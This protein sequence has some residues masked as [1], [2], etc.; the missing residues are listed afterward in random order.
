MSENGKTKYLWQLLPVVSCL[1]VAL[2][3]LT[4]PLQ[5]YDTFWH[6]A[7]GRAMV[8]TGSYLEHEIFSYT[9]A[10][11]FV[12]SHS[13]LAQ[14]ILYLVW[15]AGGA[16]LL[17]AFKLLVAGIVFALITATAR[18]FGASTT[19][20]AGLA[21]VVLV[22]GMGRIVERPEI[23]SI[24]LQALII[25]ILFRARSTGYPHRWLWSIP[26]VM[27]VWDYLHG[28]L[29]G[30]I[31]LCAF[32]GT[33]LF[34]QF[35]LPKCGLAGLAGETAIPAVKRL[36]GWFLF[37]LLA[38]S[39]HPNGLLDYGSF[40]RIRDS[41]MGFEMYAEWMPPDFAQFYPYWLFL[42]IA[43]A[44][45]LLCL[46]R[47]DLTALA[48]MLPFLYLSLT[49]NRAVLAFGLAAVPATAQAMACMAGPMRQWRLRKPLAVAS[50][51][52]LLAVMILYK[53]VY[54]IDSHRFG[55]GISDIAFPVGSVRFVEENQLPGNM[56]NMDAFGGYLAFMAGPERKI[57]NYNQ[58]G[59]FTAL[60]DYLHKPET[61]SQWN[62]SYAF[63]GKNEELNLFK[64]DGFVPVYWEPG[65]AVF[66][67]PNAANAAIIEKYQLHYFR[68]LLSDQEFLN[69][70]KDPRTAGRFLQ[71]AGYYLAYRE[72]PRIAGLFVQLLRESPAAR[73]DRQKADLLGLA[74]K[75]N[76]QSADILSL[77]GELAYRRGDLAEAQ[78]R[79]SQ[80]LDCDS[81][82]LPARLGL[83]YVHYDRKHFAEA[84]EHFALLVRDHPQFADAHYAVGLASYRLCQSG[85]AEKAFQTFLKLAPNSPYA[86]KAKAFLANLNVGC[87]S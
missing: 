22:M 80:S 61:R 5:D 50:V 41:S 68:P 45:I 31:V 10:G 47:V 52:A 54:V 69:F 15:A 60:F 48:V 42:G 76:A 7:Y 4:F 43:L 71:E 70:G 66:V 19:A 40:L 26:P 6:M 84:Q 20:G 49:Y 77:Q 17:L 75:Y 83:G 9:A 53:Q 36:L 46:R 12:P 29:F 74:L 63:V 39:L 72:D 58:P 67:K 27:M 51:I 14:L 21:L 1:A 57:F 13:Q 34:R 81:N 79:F 37:T 28:G 38:M 8:E 30:L 65:S 16:N 86:E 73:D 62:I 23:F 85:R 55:T 25:W 32:V 2:Y 11:K 59:V 18:I 35:V 64:G 56:Y 44:L 3:V 78:A 87:G 82:N 24:L 33:E